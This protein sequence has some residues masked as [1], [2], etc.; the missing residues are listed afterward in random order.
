MPERRYTINDLRL[1]AVRAY[2]LAQHHFRADEGL[3]MMPP[4][5]DM[6]RIVAEIEEA[7]RRAE[8]V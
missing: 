5:Q 4:Y 6:D 8:S 7:R 2:C 1:A 3:P